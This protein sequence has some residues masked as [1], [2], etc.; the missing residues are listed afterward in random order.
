MKITFLAAGSLTTV[1]DGG[2]TGSLALGM[3]AA[4]VMDPRAYEEANRL[5]GNRPGAAVLEATI[6][7]PTLSFDG[8]GLCALTGADLGAMLD[9]TP[10]ARGVSFAVKAGQTLKL[11]FATEGC[12][13]YI[14]F[15]GGI[16]V[17]LVMGS[18]STDLK[19]RVGGLA[20]R[21]IKAGDVLDIG[22]EGILAPVD[23]LPVAPCLQDVTVHA[24][25]GPQADAFTDAGMETFLHTAWQL[26]PASD[27]M[28]LRLTGGVIESIDGV[29]VVSDGIV[30]GSVQVT[31]KGQPIILMAD[32]G[33]TGG[34]AKIATV[35]SFDLPLLAQLKPGGIIRFA[36]ITV[37]QAHRLCGA[38]GLRAR[39]RRWLH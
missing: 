25:L 37:E 22:Q 30:F 3:P 33:T 38:S 9:D 32:H 29:D 2:R 16:D 5:V 26:S 4:G 8:D 7:G 1:Q 28:G 15:R 27:R 11:G 24:V 39:L 21:A 14:A 18:R 20:G 10:V 12:R 36:P 34:Y 13:G 17:P 6:F 23:R 19:C 31:P 35:C